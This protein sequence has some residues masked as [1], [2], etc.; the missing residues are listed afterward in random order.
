MK[1]FALLLSLFLFSSLVTASGVDTLLTELE[2]TM[3]KRAEYDAI[4][5]TRLNDLKRLAQNKKDLTEK[6]YLVNQII[7]EYQFYNFDSTQYYIKRNL[8]LAKS[9]GNQDFISQSHL[10]LSK[11]LATSGRY[12]EAIEILNTID[13][14]SL[15]Q[16]QLIEYYVDYIKIY[17]DL[18]FYSPIAEN[19][20]KY[21]AIANAYSD[22][23]VPL[24]NEDS[25]EYLAI[26]EKHFRDKR[27]LLE[28]KKINTKRLEKAKPGSRSFSLITFERSLLFEL[29]GNRELQKKYLILSAIS[30]IKASVKDN[31]SLTTLALLLHKE[32]DI[33][34]AHKFIN[35]SYEDASFFKSRLR[36]TLISNILPVINEAYQFRSDQQQK[37]LTRFL[38]IISILSLLLL[39]AFYFIY[40]QLN[41]INRAQREL[42]N[43]NNKLKELNDSLR[44][45]NNQLNKAN[46]ELSEANHV[47][48]HYI[49]NF[50]TICSNYIDKM[51]GIYK[52]VNRQIAAGKLEELFA[53]TKSARIMNDE[54]NQFYKN[55][56]ETFLHIYPHFVEEIN[57][58][59]DEGEQIIPK[60]SE[61][62]NTELRVFALIRLGITDSSR[63]AN[64]LRY[65][66]NT[67]YNYRVKIKNKAKG[68]RE[69][70]EMM[71]M[72]IDSV[73]AHE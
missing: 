10:K 65:S 30:D 5:E 6:Y 53:Q 15:Q 58:L 31:A 73:R 7:E 43:V 17:E 23:L 46:D 63:I 61:A 38:Y 72:K 8:E 22:S 42:K 69:D 11:L 62:L 9:I 28:S 56:D 18:G 66:V 60:K 45:S 34:R 25:D 13:K 19:Y 50:L 12:F 64:L 44:D 55:F 37:K 36:F 71:V 70:F 29:E 67:I 35:F 24:L 14:N 59:L 47:K 20:H 3:Q 57:A 48:E 2:Q 39:V 21:M 49:G 41:K 40:R 51:D 16:P 4:K 33:R 1:H 26:K 68:N 32:G 27:D 54:I 52:H